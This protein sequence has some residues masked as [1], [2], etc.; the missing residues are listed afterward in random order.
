MKSSEF[1]RLTKYAAS[2]D[3]PYGVLSSIYDNKIPRPYFDPEHIGFNQ[4][5]DFNHNQWTIREESNRVIVFE[6]SE[7]IIPGDQYLWQATGNS[8]AL[9]KDK[10]LTS[11]IT[12]KDHLWPCE[13]V[14]NSWHLVQTHLQNVD[15]FVEQKHTRPYFADILLGNAKE[16][17]EIFFYLLK[18]NK[19]IDNNII[20]LFG[21]YRTPFLDQGTGDIDL[22]F[23]ERL[24]NLP[25]IFNPLPGHHTN[26]CLSFKGSFASQYISKHIQENSWISVVAETLYDSRI[27]FPTEKTGKA[28]MSGKPFI[29]LGSCN[30]L[31][32][33][34][35]IGFQTFHPIIDETYDTIEDLEQRTK[36]AFASFLELQKQDPIVVRQQLQSVLDYNEECMRDK[37][38]LTRNAR[39]L[40]NKM[41]TPV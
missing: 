21:V 14:F 3:D 32:Q 26:T 33:L 4:L 23:K 36:Q 7:F 10:L 5:R 13:Y 1:N 25:R 15:T 40:L 31:K 27:F 29:M 35:D 8:P 24:S 28:M 12:Y 6:D 37:S 38:W 18:K 22:F 20:N 19:Q 39:N 2:A 11:S 30:F 16:M 9:E 41:K 17:R 34:R